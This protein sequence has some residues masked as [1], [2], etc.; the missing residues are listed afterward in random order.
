MLLGSLTGRLERFGYEEGLAHHALDPHHRHQRDHAEHHAGA[1]EDPSGHFRGRRDVDHRVDHPGDAEQLRQRV[2]RRAERTGDVRIATAQGQHVDVGDDVGQQPG[3]RGGEQQQ[4][5]R[6]RVLAEDQDRQ[7]GDRGD[8]QHRHPGRARPP[9]ELLELREG[10]AVLRH[11]VEHP[12]DRRQRRVEGA[13]GGGDRGDHQEQLAVLAEHAVGEEEV[14][15]RVAGQFR[16]RD[17]QQRTEAVEGDGQEDDAQAEDHRTRDVALRTP[18]LLH[19]RADELG[20]DE[21][22]HGH[23]GERQGAY[24]ERVPAARQGGSRGSVVAAHRTQAEHQQ[25]D[26]HQ[27]RQRALQ[28][29]EDVDAEQVEQGEQAEHAVGHQHRRQRAGV[30]LA[31]DQVEQQQ[32]RRE[33]E[34]R[35]HHVAGK[36]RQD[37]REMPDGHLGVAAQATG[38]GNHQGQL[39]KGK[40]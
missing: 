4:V 33:G 14:W 34:H 1:G 21:A 10:L 35:H 15:Q 8:E 3:Q 32:F 9:A 40:A 24:P 17:A 19:Q 12:R 6:V 38:A 27:Q 11:P 2:E 30:D 18:R 28:A 20:A 37:R 36:G 5:D 7:A 26:H 16:L 29:R 22:P 13:A 23:R 39:G 25:D 31:D